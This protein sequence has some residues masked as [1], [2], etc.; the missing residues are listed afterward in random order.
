YSRIEN[1]KNIGIRQVKRLIVIVSEIM[2]TN[3]L[4]KV[5]S[6]RPP[7]ENIQLNLS[8][9]I[10]AP[11]TILCFHHHTHL[12]SLI[13]PLKLLSERHRLQTNVTTL[14]RL[15]VNSFTQF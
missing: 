12:R 15:E 11:F 4:S 10:L 9:C 13:T 7:I 3:T 14:K 8:R 2:L 1:I 5:E 6:G